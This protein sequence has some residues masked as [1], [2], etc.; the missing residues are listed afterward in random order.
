[1]ELVSKRM[2]SQQEVDRA[3]EDLDR[4]P[5]RILAKEWPGRLAGLDSPGLYSWWVDQPGAAQLS[6]GLGARLSRGRIYAGQSGATAWPSGTRRATTLRARIG[7]NHLRGSIRGSTFRLT[8]G[9][10]LR[11][12]LGLAPIGSRKL[13]PQSEQTLSSWMR[14]HLSLAV[15]PF[16]GADALGNLEDK[17][18]AVLD[19]PLNLEGMPPSPLRARLSKLRRFLTAAQP[20]TGSGPIPGETVT[21]APEAIP[22]GPGSAG[23]HVT[24]HEE[25]AEILREN[26][27]GWMTTEE[28]AELVNRRRR[29]VKRDGS[30]VTAFQIHGRTRNYPQLFE[31]GG[32]K[33]RLR[34]GR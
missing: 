18:L 30:D 17:V 6:S 7:G 3:L 11:E 26:G 27:D 24:L 2:C 34:E 5:V 8:L 14:Q 4:N 25:I 16:E 22:H 9:A 10:A 19:P 28:L 15:H 13:M 20:A 33:A 23:D 29:Y 12:P 21:E 1:M 32:S 31:R